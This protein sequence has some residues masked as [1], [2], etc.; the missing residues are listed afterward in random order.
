M[1]TALTLAALTAALGAASPAPAAANDG[2]YSETWRPQFHF[3]AK[4]NW[5]ND[6]NG[7]V[8]YNGLYHLFFQHNPFGTEWGNM[9]WGHAVSP[10]LVH[11]AERP[12]ALAPDGHGTCFSGSAVVDWNNTAGFAAPDAPHPPLVAFYTGA[13]VPQ[14][15][16]GPKFTQCLAYSLDG[17]LTW[18]KYAGNPVMEN[19]IGDNRDPKVIWHAPASKWIMALYLDK[20]DYALFGS[21]DLKSWERLCDVE[22]P[23]RGECPDFFELPVDGDPA[24]TRWVFVGGNGDYL[25]GR[26]DGVAFTAVSPVVRF[27][28]GDHF[29]APQS[30]S[31]IPAADGRRIQIGW[32]R[33]GAY[34]G[35]PFN[36]QMAFP[37]ELTL[38]A[39]P[40]GPRLFRQPVREIAGIRENTVTL[41]GVDL[42][43]TITLDELSGELCDLRVVVA[44]DGA[45]SFT[46]MARGEPVTWTAATGTL[47]ALGREMPAALENGRVEIR[48]LADRASFEIFVQNGRA[49]MSQC[50][51]PKPENRDWALTVPEGQSARLVALEGH[52]LRSAWR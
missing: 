40:D 18:E 14:V 30:W 10:D 6:P 47:T 49:A 52:R 35:M 19:I 34:P 16:G 46:L 26:F 5:L 22:V 24:D 50:F 31:D 11:W 20:S 51:L 39:T 37:N 36:Q 32:M 21:A 3:T 38:R 13:P 25:V 1:N 9:H 42:R 48:L 23:G 29:Y 33:G 27:D 28:Y 15:E 8:F 17:G 12:I 4:K 2:I 43:G 41:S 45:E 44:P 7:L